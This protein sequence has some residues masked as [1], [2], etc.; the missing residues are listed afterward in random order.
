MKE[1]CFSVQIMEWTKMFSALSMKAIACSARYH[2]ADINYEAI[3][4]QHAKDRI[5]ESGNIQ[6]PCQGDRHS[7]NSA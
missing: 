2:L 7:P 5:T 4:N 6:H 1:K 3:D